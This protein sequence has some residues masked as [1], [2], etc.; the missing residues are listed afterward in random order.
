ML[1]GMENLR[2]ENENAYCGIGNDRMHVYFRI[3]VL[4]T[5]P[6]PPRRLLVLVLEMSQDAFE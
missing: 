1:V 4:G 3:R 5:S 2:Y 6:Y